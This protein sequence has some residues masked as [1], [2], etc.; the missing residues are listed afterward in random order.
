M[1]Q[2]P[3][4][5]GDPR[6]GL[7]ALYDSALP[8][9]YG[10]L[11]SRCDRR[12]VA[13]DLTAETFLAA[14]DAVRRAHPPPVTTAWLI[15]VARHK[16]VDHWRRQGR[17]DRGLRAVAADGGDQL[18]DPWDER[19]DALRAR[20]TLDRLGPHHRAA[21]TLRYLDDLPVNQV[22]ELLGRTLH[23][24]EALL[25]RARAAF[26]RAYAETT[27]AGEEDGRA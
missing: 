13:E 11:L 18:D 23:A 15:G 6:A 14:V 9:V 22:A 19:L 25:V 7:L 12:A 16:L 4:V 26:R 10:Y 1:S 3:A 24:T 27:G 21:L 5:T 17:E 20:E 2:Q 8:Q